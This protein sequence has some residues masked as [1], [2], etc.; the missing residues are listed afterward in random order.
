MGDGLLRPGDVDLHGV[1]VVKR[2]EQ[3]EEDLP[4]R[5]VEVHADLLPDDAL[6]LLHRLLGEV[7]VLDEVEEDLEVLPEVGRAGEQVTGA[8]EGRVGVGAGAGLRE[9]FEGIQFFTFKKFVFEEVGRAPGQDLLFPAFDLQRVVDGAVIG[10][11]DRVGGRI[12]G[13][14]IDED[15]ESRLVADLVVGVAQQVV[16]MLDDVCHVSPPPRRRRH[17]CPS[18]GTPCR[19]SCCLPSR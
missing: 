5:L 12:T 8:V 17:R 11:D 18:G 10:P 4:A 13:F 1:L 3:V 16:F 9:P 7:G 15:G 6:L 14:R 2:A 19:A